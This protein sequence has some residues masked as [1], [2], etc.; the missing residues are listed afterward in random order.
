VIDSHLKQLLQNASTE[1]R[2]SWAI[3]RNVAVAEFSVTT[4][5]TVQRKFDYHTK[6][7]ITTT[8]RGIL[9]VKVSDIMIAVVTENASYECSP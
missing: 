8:D 5:E 1:R 3:V 9:E 6:T 7:L 2:S 4:G